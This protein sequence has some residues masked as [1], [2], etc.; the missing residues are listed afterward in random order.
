MRPCTHIL[1]LWGVLPMMSPATA[2]ETRL[3][4]HPQVELSWPTAPGNTY[5]LQWS[6]APGGPWSDLGNAATGDGSAHSLVDPVPSGRFRWWKPCPAR[7]PRLPF[8]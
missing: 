1:A 6:D 7:N 5:Q 3:D 2:V 8:P 4:I